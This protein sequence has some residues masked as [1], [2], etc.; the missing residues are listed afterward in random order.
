MRAAIVGCGGIAAVHAA[1]V[2][3]IAGAELVGFADIRLER[4]ERF[5]QQYGGEAFGSLEE[6]MVSL[7]GDRRPGVLHLCTPHYLHAPMAVYGLEQG[8][9][10]FSEKPPVI[11]EEELGRLE[12]AV[13]RSERRLGFCFQNRYNPSVLAVRKLLASGACGAVLGGRGL[14][15]WNRQ[16]LY[17]T[18]SGWR[19]KLATEGG[20]VLINQAVHTMDLL[21]Q[22]LGKPVRIEATAA[23]HHL[24]G[25]IEVEDTMEAL[26]GYEGGQKACF[27]A[28]TAYC[29]DMPPLIEISCEKATLRIEEMDVTCL[30]RDGRVDKPVLEK[31]QALG[32][33]Y[34]GSGHKDCIADFYR[35]C[36]SGEHFAQDLDGV[37]DT[38][39]LMLAAYQ[40]VRE[41]ATVE[42]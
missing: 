17:Y 16:E 34:W 40:S 15:T 11:R 13:R 41:G 30:W 24:K 3:Q 29:D 19:G 7:Q 25:V 36:E 39:W 42:L 27:Y 14:V 33:S 12:T 26:I 6:M 10:V 32:K 1:S 31:K 23:N 4:A 18:E 37:R 21:T 9:H 5:A 35:C 8:V 38:V 20:G 28:T 2:S 22:F